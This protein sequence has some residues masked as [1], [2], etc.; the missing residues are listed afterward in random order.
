MKVTLWECDLIRI[1]FPV[2]L[3]QRKPCVVHDWPALPSD[4]KAEFD[5][6][7]LRYP[8]EFVSQQIVL[9]VCGTFLLHPW[10]GYAWLIALRDVDWQVERWLL[11]DV[12][13]LQLQKRLFFLLEIEA[14]Y[15]LGSDL[16]L[17]VG[18]CFGFGCQH[19][20]MPIMTTHV[21]YKYILYT[22]FQQCARHSEPPTSWKMLQFSNFLVHNIFVLVD[23]KVGELSDQP[24]R[25]LHFL[26]FH[27]VRGWGFYTSINTG[28]CCPC[29]CL[30]LLCKKSF[31]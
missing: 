17:K 14:L 13:L 26:T 22:C 15:A 23:S 1:R 3:P 12:N 21:Y 30:Q 16:I 31:Y 5:V 4:A 10:I 24:Q 25:K 6:A 29:C 7:R 19:L 18:L 28:S 2:T 27:P 8:F 20:G 11:A 9:V